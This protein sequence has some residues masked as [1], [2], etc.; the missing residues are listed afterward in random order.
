MRSFLPSVIRRPAEALPKALVGAAFVAAGVLGSALQA[1]AA[2]QTKE[3]KGIRDDGDVVDLLIYYDDSSMFTVDSSGGFTSVP[4]TDP[5]TSYPPP[6]ASGL[7][8][9]FT[10]R[11]ASP[12]S[13]LPGYDTGFTGFVITGVTGSYTEG[14]NAYNV[15]SICPSGPVSHAGRV[16]SFPG[17][18]APPYGGTPA[19]ST[20]GLFSTGSYEEGVAPPPLIAHFL[21]D[22]LF[23]PDAGSLGGAF[24][25]GGIVF[26]TEEEEYVYQLFTNPADGLYA[27][28]GSGTWLNVSTSD[29]G[30][31]PWLGVGAAFGYSRRLRKRIKGSKTPE[32]LIA[33]G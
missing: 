2:I 28:C 20:N 4:V 6:G 12:L 23:N 29:P 18:T 11:I 3:F 22:N 8:G 24:S 1:D 16:I 19:D 5:V 13:P 30:P 21:S 32:V 17:C 10:D 27:G 26:N 25:G 33:I 7:P 15:K 14:G 31:L 9:P